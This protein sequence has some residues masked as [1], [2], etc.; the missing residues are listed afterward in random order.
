MIFILSVV[1]GVFSNVAYCPQARTALPYCLWCSDVQGGP[2]FKVNLLDITANLI[3][4]KRLYFT[5]QTW[6]RELRVKTGIVNNRDINSSDYCYCVNR[7]IILLNMWGLIFCLNNYKLTL[8]S[9][10][11]SRTLIDWPKNIKD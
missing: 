2:T 11:F 10:T 3:P 5:S 9:S 4:T 7:M 6:R 8:F 1:A